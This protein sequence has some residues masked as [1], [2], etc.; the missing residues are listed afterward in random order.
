MLDAIS[1][2]TQVVALVHTIR[3]NEFAGNADS[4]P[5]DAVLAPIDTVS[6]AS[7]DVPASGDLQYPLPLEETI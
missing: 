5:A 3:D 7:M 2:P 4:C 1:I 6:E